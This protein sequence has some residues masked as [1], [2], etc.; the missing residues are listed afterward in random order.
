MI[1]KHGNIRVNRYCR[2]WLKVVRVIEN[3]RAA[4]SFENCEIHSCRTTAATELE[5]QAD[6]GC[7]H[8][9]LSAPAHERGTYTAMHKY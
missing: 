5:R 6:A 2:S 8:M 7:V 9:L 3:T 1:N 4:I